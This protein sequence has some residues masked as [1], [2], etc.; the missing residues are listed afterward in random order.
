MTVE[1]LRKELEV[2]P[3]TAAVEIRVALKLDYE[4]GDE[5]EV[6]IA[7]VVYEFG[8]AVIHIEEQA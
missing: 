1:E 8:Q 4:Q 6:D 3:P 5:I 7:R 2:M